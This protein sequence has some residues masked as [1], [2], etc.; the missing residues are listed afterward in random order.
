MF[1]SEKIDLVI[2]DS[3]AISCI[4]TAIVSKLPVIITT[5]FGLFAGNKKKLERPII[6]LT[7]TLFEDDDAIYINNKL[8]SEANPTTQH[9]SLWMRIYRD[10]VSIP[11]IMRVL[12]K[13]LAHVHEFQRKLG[14]EPTVDASTERYNDIPKIINNVFGIE[15]ARRHS[16][17]FHM[18]GP[19]IR[20]SYPPLDSAS[21]DFLSSHKNIAYIAF[22]QHAKPNDQDV[23]IIMQTLLRMLEQGNIDGI[24]WARLNT[25][26]LPN[27]IKTLEQ[28][29]S[30]QEIV[31]HKDILL[32]E[33]A[34]Q[35]AILEH[36]STSFFISHGGVGSLHEA[37][38]NGVRLFVYP[39]FGDQPANARAIERVGVG[40]YMDLMR[41]KFNAKIY[42]SF[43]QRLHQVAVD[44]QNEIQNAIN[45]YSAYVQV[46]ATN[47]VG[48]GADLME[49]SLFASN[50][51][52]KLH[53]RTDVGYEIHW[54]K[55]NNVD[56]YVVFAALAL[57]VF[58]LGFVAWG[59][60]NGNFQTIQKLKAL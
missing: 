11:R 49:E 53:Y 38:Y 20:G 1:Q 22:G 27:T 9:E 35:F 17:L 24:I 43:Y 37:L 42:E 4:D 55:R 26:Q 15:V 7:I 52:G 48:R 45:R 47:A 12:S 36:A 32:M 60:L 54:I 31:N 14:L 29:Y 28:V 44:P 18:V 40:K 21:T 10:Y 59:A 5:T 2:C 8:Y 33:W 39:F 6:L 23:K 51:Q 25:S 50:D 56:I 57:I 13:K 30:H 58:K 16:P 19:I 3:F 46:A 41:I 34:P